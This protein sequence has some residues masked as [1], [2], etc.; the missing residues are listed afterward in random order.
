MTTDNKMVTK[1]I[2]MPVTTISMIVPNIATTFAT[3]YC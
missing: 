3:K 1:V 2:M